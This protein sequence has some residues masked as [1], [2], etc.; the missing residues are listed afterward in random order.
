MM[1]FVTIRLYGDRLIQELKN[2]ENLKKELK[3]KNDK[4]IPVSARK[5]V[6]ENP[7]IHKVIFGVK[8]INHVN[9]IL[10][11]IQ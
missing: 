1:T 5:Y 11:D 9:T 4:E 10:E 6:L 2:I 7:K 3:I 8:S